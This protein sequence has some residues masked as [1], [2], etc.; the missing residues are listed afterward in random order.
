MYQP[1]P[2]HEARIRENLARAEL[3]TFS[4][5]DSKISP[6][7]VQTFGYS[8]RVATLRQVEALT[9]FQAKAEALVTIICVEEAL[10][11][12]EVAPDFQGPVDADETG[13]R[14]AIEVYQ[15]K[16]RI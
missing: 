1:P 13:F 9:G 7:Y 14:A 15:K 12:K 11:F 5:R 8:H 3:I 6:V 2:L 10:L 4:N 16:E